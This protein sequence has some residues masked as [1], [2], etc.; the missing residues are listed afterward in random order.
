LSDSGK[1]WGEKKKPQDSK[2]AGNTRG[3]Y[4]R[5]HVLIEYDFNVCNVNELVGASA[6]RLPDDLPKYLLEKSIV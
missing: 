5:M 6:L 1:T 4:M 2:G 3:V